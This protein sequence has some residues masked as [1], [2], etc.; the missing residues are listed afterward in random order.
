MRSFL[1]VNLL[2]ITAVAFSPFATAFQTQDT[3]AGVSALPPGPG[4]RSTA[5]GGEIRSLDAVR[6]QFILKIYGGRSVKVWFDER[7]QVFRDGVRIPLLTLHPSEHA[8]VETTLDGTAIFA[9]E[10][11]VQTQQPEGECRGRV[12]SY[13]AGS[14]V[15]KVDVA[16]SNEVLSLLVSSR[17]TITRS[18]QEVSQVVP[19]VTELARGAIVDLRF[20]GGSRGPGVVNAIDLVATP[21][22]SFDF[23]GQLS[24]LDVEQGR[25]V[26]MDATGVK[27]HEIK[28]A[29]ARFPASKSMH[30]GSPVLVTAV[31][32]GTTYTATELRLQP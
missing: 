4:G 13:D 10:I 25:L 14:G 7:T 31:F 6:D 32:D 19:N 17:T 11:H 3:R 23:L 21:G 30:E 2:S 28:F 16:S 15:L 24:F 1:A 27:S 29:V 22:S 26:V 8:S 5:L 18:A 9:R 20:I 12:V